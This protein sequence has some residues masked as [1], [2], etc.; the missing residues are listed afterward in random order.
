LT[1]RHLE[2]SAFIVGFGPKEREQAGQR[3]EQDQN[4]N[5]IESGDGQKDEHCESHQPEPRR[6]RGDNA[7]AIQESD[8]HEIE[9]IEEKAGVGQAAEHQVAGGQ[10]ETLAQHRPHRTQQR[11]AN[12]DDRLDPGVARRL[13]QQ[14]DRANEGDK[15]RRAHFQPESFGGQQ[16]PAF[17]NEQQKNESDREPDSPKHGVN[18]NGQD[19]AAAGLEQQRDIFDGGEQGKLEL[20]EQRHNSHADRSQGLLHLLAKAGSRRRRRRRHEAMLQIFVLI[21]DGILPE[22]SQPREFFSFSS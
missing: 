8:R 17:V 1:R 19:H 18:P 10:V 21:H 6:E 16:V 2:I 20:G 13:L 9:Q 12:A 4:Q 22:I 11:A 15:H 5:K 7:S 14:D 3:E